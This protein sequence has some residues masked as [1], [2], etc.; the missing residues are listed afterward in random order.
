MN[1]PD[2]SNRERGQAET[3]QLCRR[4]PAVT[5][6][7]AIDQIQDA[8]SDLSLNQQEGPKVW[9]RAV[10]AKPMDK[11]LLMTWLHRSIAGSQWLSAQKV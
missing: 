8:L 3:L 4:T 6:L 2:K 1:Q 11:E 9:E 7:D 5:D 10:A